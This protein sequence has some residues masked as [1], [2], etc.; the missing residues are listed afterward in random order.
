MARRFRYAFTKKKEASKGKLSIGLAVASVFLFFAVVIVAAFFLQGSFA[1][2]TGGVCLFA[3]LI[4]VYGFFMGLAGFSEE[5]R[6]HRTC[7]IGSIINGL[8][9]VGWL[10]FFLMGV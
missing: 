4:S 6:A 5:N 10:A 7:I 9:M 3:A 1:Y 2:V 8:I